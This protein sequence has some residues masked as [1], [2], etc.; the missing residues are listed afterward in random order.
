MSPT[1][2]NSASRLIADTFRYMAVKKK[3]RI[4]K[5]ACFL[6]DHWISLISIEFVCIQCLRIWPWSQLVPDSLVSPY[7]ELTKDNLGQG[8]ILFLVQFCLSGGSINIPPPRSPS[9]NIKKKGKTMLTI[10]HGWN[11]LGSHVISCLSPLHVQSWP[12]KSRAFYH[13]N[14]NLKIHVLVRFFSSMENFER[15][16]AYIF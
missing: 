13:Q 3:N 9:N 11:T 6:L 16:Y 1:V 12:P 4:E 8:H 14:Q 15:L 10:C 5:I 2:W 7:M